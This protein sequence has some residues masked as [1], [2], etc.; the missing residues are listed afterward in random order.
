[1]EPEFSIE[2]LKRIIFT[3]SWS[4]QILIAHRAGDMDR[5]NIL[6]EQFKQKCLRDQN[7]KS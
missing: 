5:V 6:V 4:L 3:P 1:M 2:Q 7:V